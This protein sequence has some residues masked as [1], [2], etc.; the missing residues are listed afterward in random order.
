MFIQHSMGGSRADMLSG[1]PI[2]TAKH[3]FNASKAVTALM[4]ALTLIFSLGGMS[5]AS[6]ATNGV[7]VTS[8]NLRAGP[9][10]QYPVVRVMPQSASLVIYGC[11]GDRTWCDVSWAGARGWVSASYIYVNYN[12][13]QTVLTS[14]IVPVIGIATVAF[15][16]AYWD[17]TIIRSPGTVIGTVT[18]TAARARPLRAAVRM[19]AVPPPSP[20]V[21]MA[22]PVPQQVVAMTEIAAVQP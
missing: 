10:T 7:A 16:V 17:S 1:N 22:A 13:Q 19:A 6:A 11:S 12:G 2:R 8:V 20:V 15:S 14:S 18:T 5:K 9:S 3:Y 21:R 4:L